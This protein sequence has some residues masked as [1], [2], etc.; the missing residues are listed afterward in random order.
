MNLAQ[1]FAKIN[2]I[3]M[4]KKMTTR[5]DYDSKGNSACKNV[6]INYDFSHALILIFFLFFTFF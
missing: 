4:S 1:F 2:V 3:E 6:F 5:F